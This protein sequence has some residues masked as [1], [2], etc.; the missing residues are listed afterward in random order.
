V[1]L[2]MS[3]PTVQN[4]QTA[5]SSVSP[6]ASPSNNSANSPANTLHELPLQVPTLTNSPR[7]SPSE[8]AR[9]AAPRRVRRVRV[10]A[11]AVPASVNWSRTRSNVRKVDRNPR[12]TD[13][14]LPF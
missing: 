1:K 9:P 6:S 5:T 2:E 10:E 11:W 14:A 8:P 4:E 7:C 12:S 3:E 13:W